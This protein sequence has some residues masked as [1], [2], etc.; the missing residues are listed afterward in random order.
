MH[1]YLKLRIFVQKA[2]CKP[3]IFTKFIFSAKKMKTISISI[4]LITLFFTPKVQAQVPSKLL[5]IGTSLNAYKGDLGNPY[6]KW[7]ASLYLGL[8]MNKDRRVN[9]YANINLGSIT[10][11]EVNFTSKTGKQGTPNSFFRTPFF[12]ANAGLHITIFSKNRLSVY[13]T[14]GVGLMRYTPK[15]AENQKFIDLLDTRLEDETYAP[16]TFILPTALGMQYFFKNGFGIGN[17]I[18]VMNTQTDYLDNIS[19]FG[20]SDKDNVLSLRFSFY[21]P[22]EFDRKKR[23]K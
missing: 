16:N 15:N 22:L 2:I 14:Q 23:L 17:Q 8:R 19:G 11:Q 4:L 21:A 20:F 6:S 9:F 1:Q 13:I 10:G 12:A 3:L 7:A 5:E 18:G